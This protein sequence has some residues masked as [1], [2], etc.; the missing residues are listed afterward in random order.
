MA[1]ALDSARAPVIFS[2]S[3][4]LALCDHP[5]NVPDE[6]LARL[7]ANNG[8][9][10]VT[11]VPAFVSQQCRDWDRG[12]EAEMKRRG[13]DR[14]DYPGY[15]AVRAELAAASPPPRATLTQ[16]ADHVEH[17]R[18]VAGVD[19]VGIGS[20]FD[21][22][23]D[24]PEGLGDVSCFPALFAEL[25]DRGWSEDDCARLAG[26]NVLRVMRD[27]EAFSRAAS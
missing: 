16:V 5:R 9:C 23:T 14:E 4:A 7:P 12:V 11:F 15:K 22:T 26:G 2:H 24:L 8:V 19:H 21:G 1:D 18:R 13:M 6:I 25:L 27:A 17:V 20:D 10:M 3:S